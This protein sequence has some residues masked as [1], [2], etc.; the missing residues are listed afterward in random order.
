VQNAIRKR[1]RTREALLRS[2]GCPFGNRSFS[3][4]VGRTTG[5]K[6]V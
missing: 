5:N 2:D 3:R 6:P 4:A 1:E